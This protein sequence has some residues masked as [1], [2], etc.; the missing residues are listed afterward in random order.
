MGNK[1]DCLDVEKKVELKTAQ[2]YASQIGAFC[3]EISAKENIGIDDMFRDL[4][5]LI[6]EKTDTR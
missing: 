5:E 3:A 4:A 6:V 1:C 2:E